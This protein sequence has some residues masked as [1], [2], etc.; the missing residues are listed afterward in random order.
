[1]DLGKQEEPR[2]RQTKRVKEEKKQTCN[3][4]S[5]NRKKQEGKK[6]SLH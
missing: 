2:P 3:L 1:M 6:G 4:G 5:P